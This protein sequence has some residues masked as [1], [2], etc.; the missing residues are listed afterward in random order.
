[1]RGITR[2]GAAAAGALCLLAAAQAQAAARGVAARPAP[3]RSLLSAVA[4]ADLGSL[5]Q[6]TSGVLCG[7]LVGV[8]YKAPVECVNGAIHSGNSVNSGNFVNHGN[9]NNSGNLSSVNGSSNAANSTAGDSVDSG[10]TVQAVGGR[11]GRR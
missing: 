9:P 7:P 1:M 8:T 6:V 2:A 10:N 3:E 5:A 11:G 4:G